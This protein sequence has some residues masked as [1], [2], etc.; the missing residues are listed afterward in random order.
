MTR[1]MGFDG[2]KAGSLDRCDARVCRVSCHTTSPRPTCLQRRTR[3]AYAF[4]KRSAVSCTPL[5]DPS[6]TPIPSFPYSLQE[7]VHPLLL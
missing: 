3:I 7:R 5:L 2:R 1:V 6:H 4:M